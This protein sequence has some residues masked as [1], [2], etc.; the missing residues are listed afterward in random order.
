MLIRAEDVRPLEEW[1]SSQFT[2]WFMRG[3]R[4]EPTDISWQWIW[5]PLHDLIIPTIRIDEQ[6]VHIYE[7]LSD[8]GRS[9]FALVW[10]E[11]F[12]HHSV[13]QTNKNI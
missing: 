9:R 2:D 10:V 13:T 7:L 5:E 11:Q 12:A 6:L 4:S 8:E 1:S 3:L